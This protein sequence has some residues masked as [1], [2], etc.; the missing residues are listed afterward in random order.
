MNRTDLGSPKKK[1]GC[2]FPLT[3]KW[4]VRCDGVGERRSSSSDITSPSEAMSLKPTGVPL[5][6]MRLGGS[7]EMMKRRRRRKK[8]KK[9]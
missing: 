2:C 6:F 8:K 4:R 5:A 7:E 3:K 1:K 9:K